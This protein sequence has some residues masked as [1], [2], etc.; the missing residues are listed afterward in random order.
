V[1]T[2]HSCR[3]FTEE[4]LH[5]CDA[6]GDEFRQR[7]RVSHLHAKRRLIT[8]GSQVGVFNGARIK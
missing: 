1:P 4:K 3:A 5:N 8:V 2:D 6:E 7:Y